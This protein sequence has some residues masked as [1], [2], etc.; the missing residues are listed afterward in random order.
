MIEGALVAVEAQV[1]VREI[2]DHQMSF[3]RAKSTTRCMKARLTI[4]VVGLCGKFMMSSF[5]RGQH[6]LTVAI[7][8][9]KNSS[10]LRIGT[11][12]TCAPAIMHPY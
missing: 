1:G 9:S 5:G 10:P 8:S 3:S 7:I 11:P 6:R 12:C 4:A 2:V